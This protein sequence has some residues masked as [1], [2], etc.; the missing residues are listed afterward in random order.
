M[1]NQLAELVKVYHLAPKSLRGLFVNPKLKGEKVNHLLKLIIDN[2]EISDDVTKEAIY[3]DAA[4]SNTANYNM[5]KVHLREKLLKYVY[6]LS[7]NQGY[8]SK[9]LAKYFKVY[10]QLFVSKVLISLKL[11]KSGIPIAKSALRMATEIEQWDIVASLASSISNKY[12]IFGEFSK[13]EYY[14]DL[15][16]AGMRRFSKERK[17]RMLFNKW[18]YDIEKNGRP[19]AQNLVRMKYDVDKIKQWSLKEPTAIGTHLAYR[20]AIIYQQVIP[21]YKEAIRLCDKAIL[22][23]EATKYLLEDLKGLYIGQK[24][25]FYLNLKDFDSAKS[26]AN[27]Q[28]KYL[29]GSNNWFV[30]MELY[31]VLSLQTK[32]YQT[33]YE[34]IE[35]VFNHLEYKGLSEVRKQKWM[36]LRA[37]MELLVSSNIWKDDVRPTEKAKFKIDRFINEVDIFRKDKTGLEVSILVVYVLFKIM[38]GQFEDIIDKRDALSRFIRRYLNQKEH[39]RSRI[40]LTMLKKIIDLDFSHKKAKKGTEKLFGSLKSRQMTYSY[41]YGGS[42]IVDYEVLWEWLLTKLKNDDKPKV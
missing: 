34:I 8:K 36:I 30:A 27:Y 40:F 31:Y 32:N 28:E 29:L 7:P 2:P 41:D 6:H 11:T 3:G 13:S 16:S 24:M 15:A 10:Q 26:F 25:L 33:A 38:Y 18:N 12:M 1:I 42:E 35:S 20:M 9:F 4:N 23:L 14:D 21:D 39:E 19:D 5:L 17:I 37:Y 22:H